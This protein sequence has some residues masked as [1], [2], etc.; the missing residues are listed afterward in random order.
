M[1]LLQITGTD[2]ASFSLDVQ[3]YTDIRITTATS[4]DYETKTSYSF[5]I[6][7]SD[8]TNTDTRSLTL[9]VNDVND[10]DPVCSTQVYAGSMAENSAQGKIGH[11]L[12][13][14]KILASNF[15]YL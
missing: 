8:G 6:K 14:V 15:Q 11:K 2:A 5:S 13:T 9:N 1:F 4:L 7:V 10:N 12:D 3:S